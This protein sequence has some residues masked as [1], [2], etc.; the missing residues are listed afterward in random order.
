MIAVALVSACLFAIG[1]ATQHRAATDF[2]SHDIGAGP[3]LIRLARSPLWLAG[4]VVGLTAYVLHAVALLL[5]NIATVQP[6]MIVG[7]V[8]AV[9]LRAAIGRRRPRCGELLAV[10]V[11]SLGL[12]LFT[13]STSAALPAAGGAALSSAAATAC[14]VGVGIATSVF[15]VSRRLLGH[16]H[17]AAMGYGATA[18][19]LFGTS[20]GLLKATMTSLDERGLLATAMSWGPWV[21]IVVSLAA[22]TLN[23]KAY[24]MAPIVYSMPILNIASVMVAISFGVWALGEVPTTS[25]AAGAV[26]VGALVLIAA[27]LLRT[28]RLEPAPSTAARWNGCNARERPAKEKPPPVAARGWSIAAIAMHLAGATFALSF[29]YAA[30]VGSERSR[31]DALFGIA[32]V[33]ACVAGGVLLAGSCWSMASARGS[34]TAAG[35]FAEPAPSGKSQT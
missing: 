14:A 20:G 24:Q 23:Q 13:I 6:L 9:P 21:V 2:G 34:P 4:S 32:C 22:T 30:A 10:G 15:L 28:A 3:L 11:T 25:L 16:L 7:V 18:G 27:G 17:F 35:P 29:G 33:A 8:L 1:N 26:Q 19:I 5:G 31:V 12:W